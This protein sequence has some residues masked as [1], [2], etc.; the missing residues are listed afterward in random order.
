M[1]YHLLGVDYGTTSLKGC[2][3]D[4]EGREIASAGRAYEL[5]TEGETVEFPAERYFELFEDLYSELAAKTRIDAF[6]IDTQGETIVFLDK[7]GKP[8]MNAVVWLD[9]RA[10]K[11]AE[12]IAA[13]FGQEKIYSVT[14]QTETPAGYPAPKILWL[15]RSRPD[16]FSRLDK[17]VLLE[18]YLLYRITGKFC[19]ERGLYSST[20]YLNVVTGGY[21]RE[22]LDFIGISE[23]HLPELFESGEKVGEY[24]GAGVYTGTLDQIAG[25]IGSGTVAPGRIT[26][27][28]G[29][30]LAV[31]ALSDTLPPYKEGLKV[32]AYYMFR[33]RYVLLMWAPTAGMA[34]EWLKK[35]FCADLSFKELDEQADKIPLGS[36]GLIVSPHLC[37][38]VMPEND[39]ALKGGV[40]GIT[41]KHTRAHF[42]R[43]VMEAVA[44]MIRQYAGYMDPSAQEIVSTGGGGKSA[45]WLK[46]KADVVQKKFTSLKVKETGCLGS[47]ALAGLGAGV[48]ASAEQA[49]SKIVSPAFSVTPSVTKEEA[50]GLFSRYC[51]FERTLVSREKPL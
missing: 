12:E 2:V 21:W 42:A 6:A 11:E 32:S 31:C 19:A 16:L 8:L 20:L 37:G 44:C 30:A 36:E 14:G 33:G 40:Y 15:K 39:P 43:A 1:A 51:A 25:V 22:M 34:L 24:K 45:V 3:F 26:E 48:Y 47:A 18:D 49:A 13:H 29:T 27:T 9:T 23:A 10:D 7:E 17:A 38:S 41:L 4:E 35:N 50:D 5:I 28:T 46:I